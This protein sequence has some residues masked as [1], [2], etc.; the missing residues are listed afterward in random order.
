[1]KKKN[2]GSTP[3][4]TLLAEKT[5]FKEGGRQPQ[6]FRKPPSSQKKKGIIF[7]NFDG[8]EKGGK[9][10]PSS[11][12]QKSEK[13]KEEKWKKEQI[14]QSLLVFWLSGGKIRK[15]KPK[16]GGERNKERTEEKRKFK[17]TPEKAAFLWGKKKSKQRL[18]KDTFGEW[19][20]LFDRQKRGKNNEK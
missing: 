17:R 9:G 10:S 11:Q 3:A 20:V 8:E 4:A 14:P 13:G 2:W 5:L 12:K 1:V 15:K 6:A 16:V 7:C 19:V 18:T